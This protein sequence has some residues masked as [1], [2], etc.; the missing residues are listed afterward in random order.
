MI[1]EGNSKLDTLRD[2]PKDEK[3]AIAGGVAIFVVAVLLIGWGILFLKKIAN[4]KPPVDLYD[5]EFDYAS[6]R[7]SIGADAYRADQGERSDSFY[8]AQ[9]NDPFADPFNN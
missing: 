4:E 9:Q 3:T 1:G 2:K 7:D 8:D 6:L 5:A